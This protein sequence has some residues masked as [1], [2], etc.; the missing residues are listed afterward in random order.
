MNIA[1]HM[2]RHLRRVSTCIAVAAVA[3]I[4][5]AAAAKPVAPPRLIEKCLTKQERKLAVSFR[6]SDRVLIKGVLLGRGRTAIALGHELRT[7]LCN[8]LPF[9]RVLAR[10]GYRVLA[11]DFRNF[12]SSG[13]KSGAATF[14]LDRD[15]AAAAK[16]LRQ[17]GATRI[18]LGGASMGG[19]AALV[20]GAAITPAPVAVINLSG[21]T[22]LG[23]MNAV[24]A[25]RRL[26]APTLFLAGR[27]D[28]YADDVRTLF[29]ES[30]S[31]QKRLELFDNGLHG[32]ALLRGAAAAN[33]RAVII[34]FLRSATGDGHA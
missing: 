27:D 8:W 13:R 26:S 19:T 34:D 24:A 3:F 11:F 9:A 4:A 5:S 32:T 12:G 1:T 6:S 28:A 2:Q 7:D 23:P 21:P 15:M 17:R 31:A 14:R 30:I 20:A 33:T 18:V 16:L 29:N 25:V 22:E 10:S